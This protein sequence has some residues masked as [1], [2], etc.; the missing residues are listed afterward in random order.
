MELEHLSVGPTERP[1]LQEVT[2]EY[3][4]LLRSLFQIFL[5]MLLQLKYA[6]FFYFHRSLLIWIVLPFFVQRGKIIF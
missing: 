5:P 3:G 6:Y 1:G 4:R 2:N